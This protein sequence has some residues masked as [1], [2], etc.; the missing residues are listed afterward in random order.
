[1]NKTKKLAVGAICALGVALVLIVFALFHGYFDRGKFEVKEANWSSSGRVAMIAKRS[2]HEALS[3]DVFF[4]LIGDHMFSPTA[5]RSAYYENRVIFAAD[6]DCL[7][8][9]WSN[10]H[11]LAV[12]CSDGSIDP[13]HIGVRK[14]Q[15]GDVAITYVNVPDDGV[16]KNN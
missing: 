6:A 12:M 8:V 11:N 14:R 9:R 7:S 13:R 16:S 10:P 4:V 3:G 5:L 1:M 15:N 2:D